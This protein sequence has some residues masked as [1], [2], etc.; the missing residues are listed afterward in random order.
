MQHE[1]LYLHFDRD[2][3]CGPANY[4]T[5]HAE[6]QQAMT[7]RVRDGFGAAPPW[8]GPPINDHFVSA[9]LSGAH[10]CSTCMAFVAGDMDHPLVESAWPGFS[11]YWERWWQRQ[12][13]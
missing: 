6:F 13:A 2:C 10:D 3:F 5:W 4:P 11:A 9:M 12:I 8:G 7:A 1:L